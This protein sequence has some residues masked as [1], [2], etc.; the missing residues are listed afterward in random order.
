MKKL[1]LMVVLA[2]ATLTINAQEKKFTVK[3]GVASSSIVGS[4]DKFFGASTGWKIGATYDI[5][6]APNLY[7]IPGIEI[8]DKAFDAKKEFD[9]A[10]GTVWEIAGEDSYT[11]K[12]TVDRYYIQIPVSIAYKFNLSDALKLTVKAGPYVAYGFSGTEVDRSY[13]ENGG[14]S[15][16]SYYKK[17][18]FDKGMNHRFDCGILA[19][20]S[21]DIKRF[22]VGVEYSHGFTHQYNKTKAYNQAIGAVIGYRF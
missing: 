3:L 7:I 13:S 5:N 20:A 4:D 22:V 11:W 9:Y 8:V 16:T 1:A 19:G 14:A 15:Y 2:L 10:C 21:L 6:I 17:E 12:G 18:I